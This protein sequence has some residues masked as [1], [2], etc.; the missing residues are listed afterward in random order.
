MNSQMN[1]EDI[2][3]LPE[4]EDG[5]VIY[6]GNDRNTSFDIFVDE[7][8]TIN[9]SACCDCVISRVITCIEQLKCPHL[10]ADNSSLNGKT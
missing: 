2:N 5:Y 10:P 7:N 3:N 1:L 8:E 9:E 6:P 4:N